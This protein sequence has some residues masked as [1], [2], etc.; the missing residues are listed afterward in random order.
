VRTTQK[1]DATFLGKDR[2]EKK[3]PG[4]A[5]RPRM[6]G[7]KGG[8]GKRDSDLFLIRLEKQNGDLV[9]RVM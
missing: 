9:A 5:E 6:D 2:A 1:K 3:P 4:G 7:Q 8:K